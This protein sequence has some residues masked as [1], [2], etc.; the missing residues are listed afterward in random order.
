MVL[1]QNTMTEWI[2]SGSLAAFCRVCKLRLDP[3]AQQETQE[4]VGGIKGLLKPLFPVAFKALTEYK[5]D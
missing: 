3:H 2:W 5:H 1:P 4:L